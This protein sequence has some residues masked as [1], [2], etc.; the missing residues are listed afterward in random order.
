MKFSL[1]MSVYL[2]DKTQHL[3]ESLLSILNQ[4]LLPSELVIVKDGEISKENE[5]V[6]GLFKENFELKKTIIKIIPIT[7]NR[8]LGLALNKGLEHCSF[9]WVAR[10][11]SDD[12]STYDR[13][14]QMFNLINLNPGYDVYGS[15]IEEF[16]DNHL[17][18]SGYRTVC[19]NNSEI[20]KDLL[21]RNP[22]NH[23]TVIFKKSSIQSVGSY[24]NYPSFEDYHLWAKMIYSGYSFK[25]FNIVTVKVRT[26]NDMI[27]RRIGLGY[28]LRELKFQLFL[29]K[30]FKPGF[31]ILL[32]GIFSRSLIRLAPKYILNMAYKV[33]RKSSI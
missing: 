23:V 2:G 32:K 20:N 13:F 6:I 25:N 9:P 5:D 17:K 24:E 11:D 30:L 14:E 16:I 18:P 33:T 15:H 27:G 26:G 21:K 12:I 7:E 4:T 19:L 1:L 22:M 31:A 3:H 8:G 10:M 28:A 29:Y